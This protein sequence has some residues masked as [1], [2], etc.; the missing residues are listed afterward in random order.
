MTS[1]RQ[2]EKPKLRGMNYFIY[3]VCL[4]NITLFNNIKKNVIIFVVFVWILTAYSLSV[5]NNTETGW[6][7]EKYNITHFHTSTCYKKP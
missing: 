5:A 3:F 1:N 6:H 2:M 4:S 7:V